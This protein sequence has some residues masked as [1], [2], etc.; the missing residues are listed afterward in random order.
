[1]RKNLF[2][3]QKKVL[4]YLG[5]VGLFAIL[6]FILSSMS[7]SEKKSLNSRAA[8]RSIIGGTNVKSGEYP[9]V[10][11]IDVGN[12]W[13]TGTLIAPQWI[14]T[15]AH[16]LN[17]PVNQI[18][19]SVGIVNKQDI[20][21]NKIKATKKIQFET[22]NKGGD[23]SND[24]GLLLLEKPVFLS[25]YPK[26]PKL[27]KDESKYDIGNM[28]QEIGWGCSTIIPKSTSDLI[29]S[30]RVCPQYK[31]KDDCNKYG[32]PQGCGY[33][34][35]C[36]LCMPWGY[37]E[38]NYDSSKSNCK[39]L[40]VTANSD[41]NKPYITV[42]PYLRENNMLFSEILQKISLLINNSEY[43]DRPYEFGI[44]EET[45]I[46]SICSGDSGGPIFY[47]S[48]DGLYILGTVVSIRSKTKVIKF[49]K[50]IS[51]II[52][53]TNIPTQVPPTPMP[54]KFPPA[55]LKICTA[56]KTMDDCN[57]YGGPQG[58][59]YH[60]DCKLCLPWNITNIDYSGS[61]ENCLYIKSQIK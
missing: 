45:D 43:K 47:K 13:C 11:Y 24:I 32:G 53:K 49:E 35:S 12:G 22:Y 37:S 1:M 14:L 7:L 16:C 21:A 17:N 60:L 41:I 56:Y 61:C 50:W 18:S 4:I 57:K 38:I 48:S 30:W 40:N 23:G 51:D 25:S 36:D 27:D 5:I 28:V 9:A 46:K 31:T 20:C 42:T 8:P 3:V 59:R 10:A 29:T 39:R 15:A 54:S 34:L 58:C 55:E 6:L 44:A 26:L 2:C 33:L 52:A 19:V